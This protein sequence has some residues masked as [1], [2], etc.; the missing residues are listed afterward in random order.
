MEQTANSRTED[1]NG[2]PAGDSSLQRAINDLCNLRIR[3]WVH[4]NNL[5]I[6]DSEGLLPKPEIA[7]LIEN[8]DTV[9]RLLARQ[10]S[11]V[12]TPAQSN[13]FP[14][15]Y[16]QQS[17]LTYREPNFYAVF[18]VRLRGTL[19]LDALRKSF[20]VVIQRHSS[21][22]SRVIL[23]DGVLMQSVEPFHRTEL[24][25]VTAALDS[26]HETKAHQL[27]EEFTEEW[28]ASGRTTF[29]ARLIEL[30]SSEHVLVVAWDHLFEDHASAVLVFSELWTSYLDAVQHH[31]HPT[32]QKR[33]PQYCEY[34]L[35]QRRTH[36]TWRATHGD[37]WTSRLA[38]SRTLR[39]TPDA[40]RGEMRPLK[41]RMFEITLDTS[42][43][44]SIRHL[45]QREHVLPAIVIL[46]LC[47]CLFSSWSGQR[48]FTLPFYVSGRHSPRHIHVVGYLAHPVPLRIE[49]DAE[50]T[51]R[52][53]L[54]LVFD[55]L[56]GASERLSNGKSLPGAPNPFESPFVQWFDSSPTP[57]QVAATAARWNPDEAGLSIQPFVPKSSAPKNAGVLDTVPLFI[58]FW[59]SPHGI[60]AKGLY[61]SELFTPETIASFSARL[62][63]AAT[64]L[65]HAPETRVADLKGPHHSV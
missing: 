11:Q 42:L 47:A 1:E 12:E 65:I 30:S 26:C 49:V 52:E 10:A 60:S 36:S 39:L 46:T 3:T 7:L 22:R 18:S 17:A 28:L 56:I 19:D 37:Y 41:E 45:A 54:Q 34:A 6:E 51:F 20:D 40:N 63:E 21:L 31:S 2:R 35:W 55:E 48:E 64:M 58:S 25:V 59:N 38:T 62:I 13:L 50:N 24:P 44:S 14:L 8:Q 32:L 53:L 27:I 23:H 16:Q 4:H 15:A 57:A 43:S 33:V 5:F 9:L 29:T 61:R